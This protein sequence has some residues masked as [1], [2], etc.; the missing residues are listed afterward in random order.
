MLKESLSKARHLKKLTIVS[1]H[2]FTHTPKH[3]ENLFKKALSTRAD[4]V[5]MAFQANSNE[6]VMDLIHFTHQHRKHHLVTLA[7]GSLGKLARLVLPA[8]GSLFAYTYLSAPKAPG[9]IDAKTLQ[10]HLKFYYQ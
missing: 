9:Q 4:I 3:L 7:M 5:K 1:M 6:D 10:S 8:A 2:D